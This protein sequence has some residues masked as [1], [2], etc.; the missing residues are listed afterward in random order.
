VKKEMEAAEQN[1]QE[2]VG[3]VLFVQRKIR[4]QS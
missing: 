2:E 3:N 4:E 1:E